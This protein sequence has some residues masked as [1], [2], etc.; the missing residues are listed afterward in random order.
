MAVWWP[1]LL[2][3]REAKP[4]ARGIEVTG[5]RAE[6][7]VSP[8]LRHVRHEHAGLLKRGRG[9][10]AQ[11][12]KLEPGQACGIPRFLRRGSN[13]RDTP[14]QPVAEHVRVRREFARGIEPRRPEER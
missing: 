11:V 8:E 3:Q 9:L 4:A 7:P 5:R 12:A 6:V 1:V 13:G 10:A 14:P 2:E